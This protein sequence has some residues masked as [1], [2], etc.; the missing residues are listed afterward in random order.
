MNKINN[1]FLPAILAVA[2]ATPA[3]ASA[4]EF[5]GN[6]A[7]FI[8]AIGGL[9]A[10]AIPILIAVAVLVFIFGVI[11]F[12]VNANDAEKRKEASKNIIFGLIG[13][14]VIVSLF[15]LIRIL[16]GAFNLDGPDGNTLDENFVPQVE[17]RPGFE[18]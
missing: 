4:Q 8:G 5:L 6:F 1:F 12:I 13:L 7:D 16:Q 11:K 15:G 2:L 14:F 17:G 18:L 10:I 3:L 9:V